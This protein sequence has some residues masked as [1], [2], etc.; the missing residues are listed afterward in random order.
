MEAGMNSITIRNIPDEVYEK[1]KTL[2]QTE[3]RSINNEFVFLIEKGILNYFNHSKMNEGNNL[4][5]EIQLQ[6]WKEISGKWDDERST[7]DIIHDIYS[8]RT[9]GR[10]VNL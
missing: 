7:E 5:K 2:A 9:N 4:S 1:V 3:R 6:I 10:D 8:N